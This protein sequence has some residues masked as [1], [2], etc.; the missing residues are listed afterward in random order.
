ME[1]K[2]LTGRIIGAAITVRQKWISF[3]LRIFSRELVKESTICQEN[4]PIVFAWL[5]RP[6]LSA[7]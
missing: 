4:F 2:E 3:F 7:N 5:E 1:N 6:L